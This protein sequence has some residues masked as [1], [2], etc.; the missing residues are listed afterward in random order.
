M[1]SQRPKLIH[2]GQELT[3]HLGAGDIAPVY[4]VTSAQPKGR[5]RRGQEPGTADPWALQAATQLV[6]AAALKGGDPS[7]DHV[8]I[9]YLDGDHQGAGVHQIIA[10]EARSMSLFGGRRVVTVVHAETLEWGGAASTGKRKR[11]KKDAGDPLERV[12]ADI[13]RAARAPFVLIVVASKADRRKAA[14]KQVLAKAVEVAVP[15]LDAPSLQRY[16]EGEGKAYQIRVDRDVAQKIWDRLG[17]ADAARLRQTADRLLLDAGPSGHLT[18]K[19]VE[20][21]VPIDRDAAIFAITDALTDEDLPR[22]FA[23][24]HLLLTHGTPPLSMVAFLSSHYR[25]LMRV[26]AARGSGQG[27]AEIASSLGMHPFR[28]KRMLQQLRRI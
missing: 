11:S 23:V 10:S 21:V 14:W 3:D 15:P 12:V 6:E 17:G 20:E 25:T 5:P 27:E 13:D 18:R 26:G 22:A 7:L 8:R 4:V 28:V 9:D 2:V 19:H 16:M 24:L 1:A